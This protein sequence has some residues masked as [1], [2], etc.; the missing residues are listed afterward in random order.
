MV[1]RNKV[2]DLLCICEQEAV[3]PFVRHHD[4]HLTHHLQQG[5]HHGEGQAGPHR[6]YPATPHE[7]GHPPPHPHLH[8]LTLHQCVRRHSLQ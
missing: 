4:K 6:A 8:R 1:R 7:A 3:Q 2:T 5:E